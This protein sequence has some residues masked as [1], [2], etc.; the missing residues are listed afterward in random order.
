MSNK[1]PGPDSHIILEKTDCYFATMPD[2]QQEAI[3]NEINKLYNIKEKLFVLGLTK[4]FSQEKAYALAGYEGERNASKKLSEKHMAECLKKIEEIL[5]RECSISRQE[6]LQEIKR[7]M[8]DMGNRPARTAALRMAAEHTKVLDSPEGSVKPP[9]LIIVV[10]DKGQ[11]TTIQTQR[12]GSI[13]AGS[14]G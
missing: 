5:A 11:V 2:N 10:G 6:V 8:N 12:E 1:I 14:E 7:D 3:Y 9:Q 4:G 13:D